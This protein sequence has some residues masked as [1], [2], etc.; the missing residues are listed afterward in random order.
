MKRKN[1][2]V[3]PVASK[4][5]STIVTKIIK[6]SIKFKIIPRLR[7]LELVSLD[8][9]NKN[10]PKIKRKKGIPIIKIVSTLMNKK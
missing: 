7:D 5:A 1:I 6:L 8:L 4:D 9:K 2:A 3:I 10:N